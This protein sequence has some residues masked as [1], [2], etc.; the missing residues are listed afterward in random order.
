MFR[1]AISGALVLP[2]LL[3]GSLSFAAW[4]LTSQPLSA[5]RWL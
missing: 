2:A 5:S 1:V 4:L 3:M